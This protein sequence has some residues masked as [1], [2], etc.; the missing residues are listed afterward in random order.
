MW[1]LLG[2]HVAKSCSATPD[3]DVLCT[4]VE[5]D[6]CRDSAGERAW[7]RRAS[8]GEVLLSGSWQVLKVSTALEVKVGT[9]VGLVAS[10]SLKPE[11]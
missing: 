1:S 8:V 11:S 7:V 2:E 10:A 3:D 4:F 9:A 6:G 5:L